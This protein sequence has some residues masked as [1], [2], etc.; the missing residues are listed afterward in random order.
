MKTIVS[1]DHITVFSGIDNGESIILMADTPTEY[2][3]DLARVMLREAG[4]FDVTPV[5]AV[6]APEVTPV[7]P[8][9]TTPTV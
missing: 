9:A 3:D 7:S 5:V 6:V 1:R 2:S 8:D 4:V